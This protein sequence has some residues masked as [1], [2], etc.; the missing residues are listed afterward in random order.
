LFEGLLPQV[1]MMVKLLKSSNVNRWK[2]QLEK[3]VQ[4]NHADL[5]WVAQVVPLNRD[6]GLLHRVT[7]T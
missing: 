3:E 6:K 4:L 2:L 1:E 5:L 7:P